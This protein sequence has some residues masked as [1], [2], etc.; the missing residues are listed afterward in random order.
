M[1]Q[2]VGL[3]VLTNQ[4]VVISK[5]RH[6]ATYAAHADEALWLIPLECCTSRILD[7]Y[8][9]DGTHWS[10]NVPS[11]VKREE[12]EKKKSRTKQHIRTRINQLA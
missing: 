3:Q 7:T 8:A 4:S 2:S 11:S 12:K 6:T 10:I 9:V 1:P 5:V